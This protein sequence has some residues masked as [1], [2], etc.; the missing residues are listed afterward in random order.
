MGF[1]FLICKYINRPVVCVTKRPYV[2]VKSVNSCL[3]RWRPNYH[4]CDQVTFCLRVFETCEW[5][6]EG[7]VMKKYLWYFFLQIYKYHINIFKIL[8]YTLFDMIEKWKCIQYV[9]QLYFVFSKT[10]CVKISILNYSFAQSVSFIHFCL[11]IHL[12]GS[13]ACIKYE[14]FETWYYAFRFTRDAI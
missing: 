13:C 6:W 11:T 5:P 9:Q 3:I 14:L 7:G 8:R 4:R 10:Y 12:T 1:L 2:L